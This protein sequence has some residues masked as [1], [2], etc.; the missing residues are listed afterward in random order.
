MKPSSPLYILW[1]LALCVGLV[2][3]TTEG[4]R[5][6]M[7][8]VI[9][10]ADSMNRNYVPMTSDSLLLQAC[11]FYDRHGSPNERMKAR[12]LLGCVYRD[13]GEAPRAVDCYQEAADCADTLADDCDYY[14]LA[15]IYSQM[16]DVFHQQLLFSDEIESRKQSYRYGLIAG[17]TLGAIFSI[18]LSGGACIILNK[19]DS[20]EILIHEAMRLFHE[21]GYFQYEMQAST[22]LMHIYIENTY[23]QAELGELIERYEN[24]SNLFD[25]NHELHSRNRQFYYYKG[26]YFEMVGRLDSAEY[27]YRKVQHPNLGYTVMNSMY[28]G[29]LSVFQKQNIADS[30]A[31]YAQLYCEVNDSSIA[32]K[33]K[34]LTARLAASYRYNTIQKQSLD[35]AEKANR[36]MQIAIVLLVVAFLAMMTAFY[37]RRRYR[38]KR[39]AL[40]KILTEHEQAVKLYDEKLFRLQLLEM[41]YKG[42]IA[43]IQHNLEKMQKE[44]ANVKSDYAELLRLKN[45]LNSQFEQSRQQLTDELN[46][47]M[48]KVEDLEHKVRVSEF[49]QKA[50]PFTSMGVVRR[51]KYYRVKEN[52]KLEDAE[53]LQLHDTV[54]DFFPD[55]LFD[56]QQVMATDSLGTN[57]CLL[58]LLDL[59][60]KEIAILLD[61]SPKQVSNYKRDINDALFNDLTATTLFKNLSA[62][63]QVL[64]A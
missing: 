56:L 14:N 19:L 21:H 13:L 63:Y 4:E 51:I 47:T 16:G 3:C 33:D 12:Y 64:S 43:T 1:I 27:Y 22:M 17:D 38:E 37:F 32:I 20:G 55:L 48:A 40:E 60:P 8:Q 15:A 7:A 6:Q 54:R 36:R 2:A 5:R 41:G 30:I 34:E 57:L 35:N 25:N 11:E 9:A 59:S 62:R 10:E 26:R 29:L 24:E 45:E 53:L 39:Q 18:N 42:T 23:K 58:V 44:N 28:K 61:I 52:K 50:I 49:Q 31:K 46:N